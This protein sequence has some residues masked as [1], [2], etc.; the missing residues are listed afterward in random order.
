MSKQVV[1]E[2]TSVPLSLAFTAN[3][4]ANSLAVL[5]PQTAPPSGSGVLPCGDGSVV[6]SNAIKIIF[7]GLGTDTDAFTAAL[8]SWQ[9][10][11]SSTG[12]PDLWVPIQLCS[13][14]AVTL[15]AAFP[16]VSGCDVPATNYFCSAIT[17][18]LGNVVSVEVVSP[19]A[20]VG[21]AH[22]VADVKGSRFVQLSTATA[23][24]VTSCNALWGKI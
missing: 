1:I 23:A 17:L 10:Q 3:S 6:T 5:T 20:G 8:W 18:N 7:F 13:F 9:L 12:K 21:T 16:G 11:K 15:D 14:T 22:V 24:G 19:T 2:T 4:T